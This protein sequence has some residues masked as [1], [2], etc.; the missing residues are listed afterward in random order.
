MPGPK[1]MNIHMNCYN[2][3]SHYR[4]NVSNFNHKLSAIETG[5]A[6]N[7]GI[8][9]KNKASES[10]WSTGR[11]PAKGYIVHQWH[12][13]TKLQLRRW[14][15]ILHRCPTYTQNTFNFQVID[16]PIKN[17]TRISACLLPVYKLLAKTKMPSSYSSKIVKNG[18]EMKRICNASAFTF[19]RV[20]VMRGEFS[21]P[22]NVNGKG[23]CKWKCEL[24]DKWNNQKHRSEMQV[25]HLISC[26]FLVR[27]L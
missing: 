5:A 14:L 11:C 25:K 16:I 12:Y 22:G 20:F 2:Y 4:R 21:W 9:P 23:K 10:E 18:N 27:S 6:G 3:H 8:T 24:I 1:Q 19:A 13:S 15:V 7:E 17:S 26:L